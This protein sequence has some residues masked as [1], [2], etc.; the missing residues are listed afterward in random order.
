MNFSA[1]AFP[2][3]ERKKKKK[4]EKDFIL[5]EPIKAA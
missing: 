1:N 4:E 2:R 5:P 3:R